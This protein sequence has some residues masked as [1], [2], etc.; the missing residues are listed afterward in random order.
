[1]KPSDSSVVIGH[2]VGE[3]TCTWLA[4]NSVAQSH[5]YHGFAG[6]VSSLTYFLLEPGNEYYSFL[7]QEF[8]KGLHSIL[9]DSV[10]TLEL[11]G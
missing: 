7:D 9:T 4:E 10:K 1:M 11:E 8:E 2:Q 6:K 3:F 5:I